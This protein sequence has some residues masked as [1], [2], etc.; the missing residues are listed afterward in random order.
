ME[1]NTTNRIE[2]ID[3]LRGVTMI[4]VVYHHI[5][6]WSLDNRDIAYNDIFIRFRMPIFFFI[7]GWVFYKA[8]R[9]WYKDT[10]CSILKKKFM[11]QIIPFLF[12][13]LL[14]MYLFN[15][16]EY[17]TSFE[18]KYGFWFTFSLFEFF[19]IYIGIEALL[20]KRQTNKGEYLVMIIMLALSFTAYYYEQIKYT[21]DLGIWRPVLTCLSYS[22][23]KNIIFFW[24][25]TYIKKNYSS[26]IRITDNQY[27]IAICISIFFAFI[28]CPITIANYT[29]EYI[30]YLFSGVTGIII[31]FTFFRKNE[32]HLSKDKRI[33]SVLQY[34]GKRT[35]DIYLLHYFII[36]Y[37]LDSISA[38]LTQN[39]YKSIDMLIILVFSLWIL[40]LSILIS[41]IIRLSPFLGHYLFGVKRTT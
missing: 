10:I 34:I 26:F 36:P 3:A 25:G 1:P 4:L 24:L 32:K 33:G 41:N 11:V 6:F 18:S 31:I 35:L 14:Y 23:M 22:K 19:V 12:F 16:P 30:S 27:V 9:L 17:M 39:S 2:F 20:N 8:N 28:I 13:M 29:L 38:W 37:H 15:G 21:T 5:A 40:S 7:S